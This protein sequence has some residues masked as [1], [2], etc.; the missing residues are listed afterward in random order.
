MEPSVSKTKV[1]NTWYEKAGVRRDARRLI[2]PD[3]DITK[4]FFPVHLVPHLSH[5]RILQAE[6]PV[7]R[8]LAAQHLFQWLKFTSHFEVAVVNR[9][10]QRIAEGRAG[11][12][13]TDDVR[14][15]AFK[16]YVDEGYHSLYSLDVCKQIENRAGIT[17]LPY[18][19]K[20]YLEQLDSVGT[21]FPQHRLLVQLLQV[22]VFETLITSILSDIPS[23]ENVI[24]VV[25]DT[26]RDHAI[27]E[28]RHHA[29]F[30]SLFQELWTQLGS[31]ERDLVASFLPNLIVRSLEP[32][33]R[34][35]RRA[36]E[37]SG[38]SAETVRA[39]IE[40]SY[41][42][43]AVLAGVRTASAKTVQLFE[44]CGVM[45]KPGA[46]EGFIKAGLLDH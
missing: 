16:I 17:A 19:F 4:E 44:Q 45:D 15:D 11:L 39:V 28:G 40:E 27:D 20:P 29:F 1:F 24:T 33:T 2:T 37:Q 18:D 13:A 14:M 6:E 9:A 21:D 26:V 12:Q 46:R 22:V 30:A 35:A 7:R 36:L 5:P 10:T 31:A 41:N 43:D 3:D 38:F 32:A 25:R 34:P 42:R 8:Y 23:D